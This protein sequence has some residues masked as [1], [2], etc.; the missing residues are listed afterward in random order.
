MTQ[1]RT[2]GYGP[3]RSSSPKLKKEMNRG[4]ICPKK[5]LQESPIF[6]EIKV[7]IL[8]KMEFEIWSPP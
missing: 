7:E 8:V 5:I 4:T 2:T 3:W 1:D 6:K